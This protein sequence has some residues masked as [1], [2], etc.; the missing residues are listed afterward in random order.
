MKAPSA[1]PSKKPS[2]HPGPRMSSDK[3]GKSLQPA[4]AEQDVAL[5]LAGGTRNQPRRSTKPKGTETPCPCPMPAAPAR[6]SSP[7]RGTRGETAVRRHKASVTAERNSK[8]PLKIA[9][10]DDLITALKSPSRQQKVKHRSR[11]QS[12]TVEKRVLAILPSQA[13][14]ARSSV[15]PLAPTR[16][17]PSS[18]K[19]SMQ[20]PEMGTRPSR[21]STFAAKKAD[22]V[23]PVEDVQG[24]HSPKKSIMSPPRG[25]RAGAIKPS[26]SSP[27][28]AKGEAPRT[29]NFPARPAA[30]LDKPALRPC[31]GRPSQ[32]QPPGAN[33]ADDILADLRGM[34][35]A[36]GLPGFDPF[37]P[38]SNLEGSVGAS[39]FG[40]PTTAVALP[41][42]TNLKR[43][44]SYPGMIHYS[45][46]A[47]IAPKRP[48]MFSDRD[49]ILLLQRI[50]A[51]CVF[52]VA[53][54][55]A[56]FFGYYML[57]ANQNSTPSVPPRTSRHGGDFNTSIQILPMNFRIEDN[58]PT[59][60]L[61]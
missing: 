55:M 60:A 42:R 43:L 5:R 16:F 39:G 28:Y 22:F 35:K 59:T 30:G 11:H 41:K 32:Q 15:Q 45:E 36:P 40:F 49:E 56:L 31:T 27:K 33:A 37:R 17:A 6:A 24:A 53:I 47:A 57:S 61:I 51:L 10:A 46:E 18:K 13:P 34:T 50:A 52:L 4:A 8:S 26:L 38:P 3:R 20:H 48:G 25:S 9:G 19:P 58:A 54:A 7:P 21:R 1:N 29:V 44:S 23:V 14:R 2:L 12:R